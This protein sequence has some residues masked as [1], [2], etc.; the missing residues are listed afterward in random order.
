MFVMAEFELVETECVVLAVPHG[1]EGGTE[2]SDPRDASMMAAEWLRGEAE[3][4]LMAGTEPPELPIGLPPAH[5]GTVILIGVD[6]SLEAI[7]TVT[8]SEAARAL[9]V[10][11][12][13]ITQMIRSGRLEGYTKGHATFVTRASVEARLVDPPHPGRPRKKARTA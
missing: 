1:L 5:G 4:W 10:S 2:G 3:H 8:A 9:G 7:D 13:R 12:P 11:R 6:V